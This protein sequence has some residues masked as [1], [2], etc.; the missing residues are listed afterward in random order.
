MTR[1]FQ[2]KRK[3]GGQRKSTGDFQKSNKES[4]LNKESNVKTP[5][6]LLHRHASH[7]S[8]LLTSVLLIDI[9]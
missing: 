8:Q 1:L 6:F 4:N 9:L 7:F 5:A 3:K 2:K